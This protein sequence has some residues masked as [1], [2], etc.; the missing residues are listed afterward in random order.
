[1]HY[2]KQL[3]I[4]SLLITLTS[5][6]SSC[7]DTNSLGFEDPSDLPALPNLN[8]MLMET[9]TFSNNNVSNQLSGHQD[10]FQANQVPRFS[11][12]DPANLSEGIRYLAQSGN[13]THQSILEQDADPY[14]LAALLVMMFDR[15]HFVNLSY[16]DFFTFNVTPSQVE[17]SGD[18][19]FWGFVSEDPET[20]ETFEI[21]VTASVSGDN[22]DWSIIASADLEEGGFE[23]QQVIE[24]TSSFNGT[25]GE[26]SIML[27]IPEENF[28]YTSTFSWEYD[29]ENLNMLDIVSNVTETETGFFEDV[30]GSYELDNDDASISDAQI[31]SQ[32]FE[33]EENF[34]EIDITRLFDVSWDVDEGFGAISIDG[35]DLCWDENRS[36]VD[37]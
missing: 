12:D 30:A 9:G 24:G 5:A 6:L 34:G 10:A 26:W 15:A 18:E 22:V 4:L 37:C 13:L 23:E 19:Y 16:I 3:L 29:N 31:D 33:E 27:D 8:Q 21:N 1:M 20:E 7:D 28:G 36:A 11:P 25:A 14:T 17:I 35:V 32:D 2:C